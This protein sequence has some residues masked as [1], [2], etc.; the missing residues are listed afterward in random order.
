MSTADMPLIVEPDDLEKHLGAKNLRIIDLCTPGVYEDGHIPGAV[1]LDYSAIIR[2]EPPVMGLLP[3]EAQLG[4][5]LSALGVTP[6]T[7]VIAYDNE[8]GG[9]A[10][11]LL[12]TLM[13]AGHRHMSL[14]NGGMHAWMGDERPLSDEVPV[15]TPTE[16]SVHYNDEWIADRPFIEAHLDD[17]GVAILDARSPGEYAGTDIRALRGGHVPGAVNLEWTEAMDRARK[18]RLK[19]ADELRRRFSALGVTPDREVILYCQTHHRSAFLFIV[20]KALG[21][22]KLKGYPGSWSDWGNRAE[23]PV[24]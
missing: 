6:E 12:W 20:L 13:S 15:I 23:T 5:I 8:G 11:R 3:D 21:Y 19:P 18:L 1:H 24:E 2:Q 22:T 9:K 14:L 7:H 17:P 10:G 4:R 16:Y